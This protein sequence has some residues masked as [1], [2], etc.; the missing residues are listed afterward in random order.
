MKRTI[1]LILFIF[2]FFMPFLSAKI[3]SANVTDISNMT[4]SD[5]W[6]GVSTGGYDLIAK[7]GETF[8]FEI[9]VK[10][11]MNNRSLHNLGISPDEMKFQVNSITPKIIDQ[12]KP[13]EIRVFVVNVTVPKDLLSAKYPIKFNVFSDEFP[14]GVFSLESEIKAVDRIKVE[15]YIFYTLLIFIILM[16]LFYRKWKQNK[17]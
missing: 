13:M 10:N 2:L 17:K 9:F 6:L 3:T 16:W 12:I 5:I 11:G 8:E 14:I 4:Y 1:I 7:K 15:L